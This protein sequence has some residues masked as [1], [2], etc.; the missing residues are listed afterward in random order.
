MKS[1]RK[2]R[3]FWKNET[4]EWFSNTVKILFSITKKKAKTKWFCG[5][6]DSFVTFPTCTRIVNGIHFGFHSLKMKDEPLSQKM[7]SSNQWWHQPPVVINKLKGKSSLKTSLL[8][9]SKAKP[10]FPLSYTLCHNSKVHFFKWTSNLK[11]KRSKLFVKKS[12]NW[13]GVCPA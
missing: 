11:E 1:T 3:N 5:K 13:R 4:V 2:K 9:L 6:D 8:S 10:C 12:S 7:C